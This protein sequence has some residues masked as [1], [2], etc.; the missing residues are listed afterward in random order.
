MLRLGALG[1]PDGDEKHNPRL[2]GPMGG[3]WKLPDAA[4]IA[5]RGTGAGITGVK[6]RIAS[7][8]IECGYGSHSSAENY[9]RLK[10][11]ISS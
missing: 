10:A 2:Q 5:M 1:L 8:S 9:P 6:P 11:A 3:S 4:K 7:M